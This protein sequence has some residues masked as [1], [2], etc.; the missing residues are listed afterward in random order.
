[1]PF[2]TRAEFFLL[3]EADVA[4]NFYYYI[5]YELHESIPDDM[6][7]FHARWR[8]ENPTEGIRPEALPALAAETCKTF[9]AAMPLFAQAS[10]EVMENLAFEFGGQNVGGQGNYVILDTE[11]SGHYVGCNLNFDNIRRDYRCCHAR[12]GDLRIIITTDIN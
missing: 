11:G 10:E 5:D 6:G 8:R 2:G 9:G 1:M 4:M 12:C 7:R 3:N